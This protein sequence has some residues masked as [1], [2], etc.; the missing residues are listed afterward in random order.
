MSSTVGEALAARVLP[1]RRGAVV[2]LT[3]DTTV[4]PYA[5]GSLALAGYTPEAAAHQREEVYL[6]LQADGAKV[7]YYFASATASDLANGTTIAA[8]GTLAYGNAYCAVIPDGTSAQVC[9]DRSQDK[10]LI[11]QTASGTA[12]LRIYASSESA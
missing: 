4:R 8:G 1:P 3:V 10:F 11:I 12:T 6:T 9:I 5:L 2:A 7:Y